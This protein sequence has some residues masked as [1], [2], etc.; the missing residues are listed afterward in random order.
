MDI[1]IN[2]VSLRTFSKGIFG[3]IDKDIHHS[4][5]YDSENFRS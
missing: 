5:I 2:P 4:I 1:P 3:F